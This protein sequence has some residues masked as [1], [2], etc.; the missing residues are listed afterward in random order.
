MTRALTDAAL[1]ELTGLDQFRNA[2]APRKLGDLFYRPMA[3]L[4]LAE[5]PK[6][7]LDYG[8]GNGWLTER[9]CQ[10]GIDVTGYDPDT[11]AIEKCLEHGNPVEYGDS[12]MLDE[13]MAGSTRFDVVICSRVLCTIADPT[14]LDAVLRDLRRLVTD[15][16]TVFVAV[17]NPFFLSVA[18]TELAE[19]YLP[20]GCDYR[21]TFLYTKTVDG[22]RTQRTEV[23]RSF[24]TYRR[25]FTNAGF[26]VDEVLELDGTDTRFLMPASDHLVFRLSPASDAEPRVS[27][28]IKTCLMEWRIIER[29]VR[30][31]VGQLEEPVRFVEKIVVVDPFEGPFL[32]QYGEPDPEAHRAAMAR[33]I[34]DGIVD[35]VIYA[36]QDS[37]TIRRTYMKWFSVESDETH[38]ANSQQ[39]FAT[40]F[41]FDSCTGDY[42]LQL[43]SDLLI[44]RNDR[45]HN[46]LNEMVDILRSDPKALF[47]PLSICRPDPLPHTPEGP[48]GDWRVEVRGCLFDRRRLQSV[49]PVANELEDGQFGMAWHRAFDRFIATS[50]YRS[51]RG[52]DPRTATIHVPNDRKTE[53]ESLFDVVGAVERGHVPAVQLENVDLNGSA[54]DWAGP[55]RSEPFV[56]VICGRNVGPSRFK[57]CF[58]SLAAQNSHEWGAVLVDDASTNGFGDYAAV[59]LANYGDRVTL[60]RNETRR[61]ALYNTWSAVTRFCIDP[62]TVIITLDADDALIGEHALSRV[63]AEYDEGADVTVGSMLRLDKEASYP[64]DFDNPRSW[65]SNVWQH[66]RTF[67]KYLFDAIDVEDLKLD[68]EWVDLANDWAFMIPIVEMASKPSHIPEPLYLYEPAIPKRQTERRERE[69]IVARILAKPRYSRLERRMSSSQAS[70]VTTN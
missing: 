67:K 16:G 70:Q 6:S 47:V 51:Y 19:K 21:E 40:L 61:G 68:G 3:A 17:C 9:L 52:G 43:D 66:L 65:G 53:V 27:L 10:Q 14:E 64:V 42:V 59:L 56:F 15:S 31:L 22:G 12:G 13:L 60:V 28:L 39:L 50:E 2:L 49:L 41:G 57:R 4:V 36:P 54:A 69:S 5:Q 25:S 20:A 24:A 38:S 58:E 33:L 55:K 62:E 37:A 34:E 63:R 35:R 44:A 26:S 45:R 23:H 7:A 11:A 29:L 1:P 32:R 18:C 46:Y 30:H 8:C 48:R